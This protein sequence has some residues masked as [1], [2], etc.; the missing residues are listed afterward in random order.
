MSEDIWL[1]A[2]DLVLASYSRISDGM[3]SGY[4]TMANDFSH[5]RLLRYL[6]NIWVHVTGTLTS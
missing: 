2:H 5:L 4:Q 1:K 3:V 6:R